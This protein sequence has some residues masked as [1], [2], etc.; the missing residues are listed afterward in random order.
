MDFEVDQK[1]KTI[2]PSEGPGN[3]R[4]E[5]NKIHVVVVETT[6]NL[7]CQRV[8]P[9]IGEGESH[10]D[11]SYADEG[12]YYLLCTVALIQEEDDCRRE[13]KHHY[14]VIDHIPGTGALKVGDS[15]PQAKDQ[16]E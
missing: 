2:G 1:D 4:K 14:K 10:Q 6:F 5:D 11:E 15:P 8:N 3:K 12:V 16:D 13:N 9:S 7:T